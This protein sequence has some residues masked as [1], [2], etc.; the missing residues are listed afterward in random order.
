MEGFCKSA[1]ENF[2]V[3]KNKLIKNNNAVAATK[4]QGEIL[5]DGSVLNNIGTGFSTTNFN[6]RT[7]INYSDY[8]VENA[9]YLRCDNI[10]LGY[11]IQKFLAGKASLRIFSGVQNAFVITKYSGLDPEVNGGIDNTIY[12]RQR[13][14]LFG[15]NIKF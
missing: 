15:A 1:N 10:T 2:T 11:T 4:S 6:S 13:Q 8:F 9:S 3:P 12:P 5:N 14:L 7:L